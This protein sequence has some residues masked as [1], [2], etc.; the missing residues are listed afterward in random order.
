MT[1]SNTNDGKCECG[2]DLCFCGGCLSTIQK[3][4]DGHRD[5][6]TLGTQRDIDT[7]DEHYGIKPDVEVVE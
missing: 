3:L 1:Y 6:K 2:G 7:W 5:A 4:R